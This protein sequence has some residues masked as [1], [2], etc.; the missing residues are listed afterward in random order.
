MRWR[1]PGW[2]FYMA[3]LTVALMCIVR[4]KSRD[5]WCS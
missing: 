1:I 5:N 3:V 2:F 4:S